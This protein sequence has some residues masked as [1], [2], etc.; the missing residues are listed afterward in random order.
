MG[1]ERRNGEQVSRAKVKQQDNYEANAEK[2]DLQNVTLH[3]II[4]Q[5]PN[6]HNNKKQQ[7]EN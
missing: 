6:L 7:C 2:H 1:K 5:T 4:K 3:Y